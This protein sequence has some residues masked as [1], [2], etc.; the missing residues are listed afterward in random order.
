MSKDT[1][2]VHFYR[3]I[4]GT[5]KS[6]L[7]AMRMAP[8][9]RMISTDD[10]FTKVDGAG[11]T[12][13]EF[14][15]TKLGQAHNVTLTKFMEAVLCGNTVHVANTFVEAWEIAPYIA[16]CNCMQ[17]YFEINEIVVP[18][19][20]SFQRVYERQ[21]HGVPKHVCLDMASRFR[22]FS[23]EHMGQVATNTLQADFNG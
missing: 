20:E 16:F 5:G 19:F 7:A 14:D 8:G 13:Y 22:S 21:T 10:F 23:T 3:G 17:V 6:T 18:D 11:R 12:V 15:P 1:Q 2:R 4:P 9:H